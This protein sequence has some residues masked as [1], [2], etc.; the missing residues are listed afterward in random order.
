MLLG[1]NLVRSLSVQIP[2][3]LCTLS[4]TSFSIC[5]TFSFEDRI[6]VAWTS[7][8]SSRRLARKTCMFKIV[9]YLLHQVTHALDGIAVHRVDSDVFLESLPD[10][11]RRL[12][13]IHVSLHRIFHP[14]KRLCLF[15]ANTCFKIAIYFQVDNIPTVLLSSPS[16]AQKSTFMPSQPLSFHSHQIYL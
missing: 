15:R 2:Y 8:V 7:A 16:R 12:H 6:E 3:S 13:E 9:F 5:L 11:R 4:I 1:R 10:W 14:L